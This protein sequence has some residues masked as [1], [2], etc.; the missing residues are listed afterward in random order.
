MAV[1]GVQ[2]VY[3]YRKDTDI[4][5]KV[6]G[7]DTMEFS[8]KTAYTIEDLLTII[9]LLRG[10]GG[11]PWDREQT[12]ASIRKNLLEEAYEVAEAIDEKRPDLLREELGDLLMQIV[13][14]AD[15]ARDDGEFDFDDVCDEVCKKLI[16]RHPHVFGEVSVSSSQEVLQNWEQIKRR[17]KHQTTITQSLQSVPRPLPQLM[18]AQKLVNRVQKGGGEVLPPDWKTV[19][20]SMENLLACDSSD[21]EGS[22]ATEQTLG[23]LLFFLCLLAQERGV[24][25]EEA[26]LQVNA[27]FT[28]AFSRAE[29]SVQETG[30]SLSDAL[31][32]ELKRFWK[33]VLS[34]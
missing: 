32:E 18:R 21:E 20:D 5:I 23:G 34:S 30:R 25:G 11:C 28:Q 10:E 33:Q 3:R 14:H 13:F 22:R 4:Y 24:D 31:E 15:M 19:S 16:K 27:G 29:Q 9:R 1:F 2:S 26:L 6:K 8:F 7:I 12:H 17:T